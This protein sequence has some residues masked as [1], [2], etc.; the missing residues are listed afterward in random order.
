MENKLLAEI[1]I[2]QDRRCCESVFKLHK[3]FL[4][5]RG[6]LVPFGSLSSQLVEGLSNL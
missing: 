3:C 2:V 5:A 1:W 6:P 4:T